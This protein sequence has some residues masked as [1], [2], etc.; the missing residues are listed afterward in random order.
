MGQGIKYNPEFG[1]VD[2]TVEFRQALELQMKQQY[3][4][5]GD[6]NSSGFQEFSSGAIPYCSFDP[7]KGDPALAATILSIALERAATPGLAYSEHGAEHQTYSEAISA[8]QEAIN[9]GN[10]NVAFQ[11]EYSG[12]LHER[13]VVWGPTYQRDSYRPA[14]HQFALSLVKETDTQKIK[15]IRK[16]TLEYGIA[17][18]VL[19][20]IYSGFDPNKIIEVFGN[21]D[22][23]DNLRNKFGNDVNIPSKKRRT[24]KGTD[25]GLIYSL[26]DN[27][28]KK[29]E[30]GLYPSLSSD[31]FNH[32]KLQL[33]D[34]GWLD[35]QQAEDKV[36]SFELVQ[37]QA[38]ALG[39]FRSM[40][41]LADWAADEQ[42]GDPVRSR[43]LQEKFAGLASSKLVTAYLVIKSPT[44]SFIR[45]K[46]G[47]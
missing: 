36:Y 31:D 27:L 13:L 15:K 6:I 29:S 35:E 46:L 5:I 45:T 44:K 22:F 18:G 8:L 17:F 11:K 41:E 24:P 28:M 4:M 14:V 21:K 9:Q 33:I 16:V 32:A 10:A 23:Q 26:W 19:A 39:V 42:F 30:H 7:I 40:V 38:Y 37:D 1:Q 43:Y 47:I 34:Y 20:L 25:Y 2:A 12:Q 3:P